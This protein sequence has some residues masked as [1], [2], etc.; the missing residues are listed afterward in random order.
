[1][2]EQNREQSRFMTPG[3]HDRCVRKCFGF[4]VLQGISGCVPISLEEVA[5]NIGLELMHVL[6]LR[7]SG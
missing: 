6:G 4:A 7:W 2:R 1:M 3:K 5:V